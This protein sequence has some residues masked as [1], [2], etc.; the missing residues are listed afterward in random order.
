MALEAIRSTQDVLPSSGAAGEPEVYA[1]LAAI[2][3]DTFDEEVAL[4]PRTTAKDVEGW[5]SFAHVRLVLAVETE[6]KV[7]FSTSDM[8]RMLSVGDIA[9]L[10]LRRRSE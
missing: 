8:E 6:F 2:F 10:I 1:R 9:A 5:D 4:T 3:R 7:R